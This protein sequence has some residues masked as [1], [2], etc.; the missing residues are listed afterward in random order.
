MT[1]EKKQK[2]KE[3]AKKIV[4]I[5]CYI[6]SICFVGLMLLTGLQSCKHAS[7]VSAES[8]TPLVSD[9]SLTTWRFNDVINVNFTAT[10]DINFEDDYTIEQSFYYN[11]LALSNNGTMIYK[12]INSGNTIAYDNEDR[13]IYTPTCQTIYINGGDDVTNETLI[14]WL[15]QNATL[16]TE[17]TTFVFNKDFNYNAP[18]GLNLSNYFG[19]STTMATHVGAIYRF[20]IN[21]GLFLSNGKLYDKIV[22]DYM[23]SGGCYFLI[24]STL[25]LGTS[26]MLTYHALGFGIS[27]TNTYDFVNYRDQSQYIKVGTG[28]VPHTYY[29]SSSTWVN[30]SWRYLTFSRKLSNDENITLN[31]FNNNNQYVP[32]EVG[33]GDGNIFNL[34][35]SVF[36][37]IAPILAVTI[38]PNLTIGI[39]IFIPLVVGIIIFIIDKI[40]K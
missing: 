1:N 28:E 13:F 35:T 8:E 40:K 33:T 38:L 6:L 21:T 24:N 32:S 20:T 14:S 2:I 30:D 16:L 36:Q 19:G 27:G 10:F 17:L 23:D 4:N 37:S 15:Q 5:I 22:I 26:G 29:E 31:K 3:K 25:T 9:L 34:F 7:S 18:L 12:Q 11:A 39:L